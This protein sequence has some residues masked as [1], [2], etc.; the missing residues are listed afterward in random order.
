MKYYLLL[1]SS[2]TVLVTIIQHRSS[3]LQSEPIK[4][5]APVPALADIRAKAASGQTAEIIA[6]ISG[7]KGTGSTITVSAYEL[8]ISHKESIEHNAQ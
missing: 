5:V 6:V 2:V 4:T 7:Q 1:P 3:F 8:S